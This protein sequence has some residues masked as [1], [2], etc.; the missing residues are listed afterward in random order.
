MIISRASW[1]V[2]A[3][4]TVSS[5]NMSSRTRTFLVFFAD[6]NWFELNRFTAGLLCIHT[7]QGQAYRKKNSVEAR[8]RPCFTP[9]PISNGSDCSAQKLTDSLI[10]YAKRDQGTLFSEGCSITL[11]CSQR[12]RILWSRQI[13]SIGYILFNAF[14]LY[15]FQ[16][17]DHIRGSS[18]CA[19]PT[20][21]LR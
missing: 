18:V 3:M 9:S 14:L 8:T 10:L 13:L 2:C 6:L 19:E 20:L 4:K 17:E 7:P 16:G 11:P 12:Q 15:L 21:C 1:W 5:V